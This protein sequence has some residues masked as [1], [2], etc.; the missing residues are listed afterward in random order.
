MSRPEKLCPLARPSFSLDGLLHPSGS[1]SPWVRPQSL[2]GWH[3]RSCL[4]GNLMQRGE[5]S[6]RAAHAFGAMRAGVRMTRGDLLLASTK[7]LHGRRP[8][9]SG[10]D[11]HQTAYRGRRR[12]GPDRRADHGAQ[13]HTQGPIARLGSQ[14]TRPG[15]HLLRARRPIWQGPC[16]GG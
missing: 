1:N 9:W 11:R 16:G 3:L 5:R 10:Q 6:S 8:S 7:H 14:R 2:S 15:A 13:G 12:T 4:A